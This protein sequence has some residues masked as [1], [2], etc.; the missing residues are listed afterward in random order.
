[1][2][3]AWKIALAVAI[4]LV[5]LL[6]LRQAGP[7]LIVDQPQRS[8][9]IVVLAGDENDQRFWK[10]IE[11]LRAGYAPQV[12]I[13]ARTDIR[14]FGRTPAELGADFIQ[15]TVPDLPVRI[16]PTAGDSTRDEIQVAQ[17]CF[18][19]A[20]N[21]LI[22]TS[23]YHTRRALSIVR[24]RLPMYSWS[25]SAASSGLMITPRWWARR[26]LVKSVLL[27]WEKLLWWECFERFR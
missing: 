24:K 22:V 7:F 14:A 16:C 2:R 8:D 3:W 26:I 13:D 17:P 20:R 27:E 23:D 15:R 12:F 19:S 11:M 1:M 10:A 25:A 4:A 6:L 18:A 5:T 21:I 9:A